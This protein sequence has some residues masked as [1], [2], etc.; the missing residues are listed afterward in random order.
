MEGGITSLR[1]CMIVPVVISGKKTDTYGT[2]VNK[3]I[4]AGKMAKI[5]L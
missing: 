3:K 1:K 4:I 5:K 2:R